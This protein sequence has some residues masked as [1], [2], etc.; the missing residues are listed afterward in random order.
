[1]KKKNI[2]I[3]KSEI[4]QELYN[5]VNSEIIPDLDV[6]I[7]EFWSG[8][9]KNAN[10][11]A[12]INKSL[13]K[14]REDIQKKI[15]NWH[16][17]NKNNF[18]INIYKNFLTEIGY[19]V[20]QEGEFKIETTNVDDEIS[21][22][23]GP[24]LVVPVDNARY[25]LNAANARWGS[26]YDALYG[27]DII[28]E[29]GGCQK[30]Q[31]YNPKRG[32]KVISDGRKFLDD[33]FKL[34]SGSWTQVVKFE[35]VE[36]NLSFYL[37]NSSVT[38]LEDKAKFIG[39]TGNKKFPDSLFLKNNNLHI[40]IKID[41]NHSIGKSDKAKISDIIFESAISTIM[42]LE[43]SVA[44]IDT[45]DKVKCYRNWLGIMK[46]SLTVKIRKGEKFL[47]RKL[48]SDKEFL[49]KQ[50]NKNY[51]HGRS[52]LLIRNVGH[53]MTSPAI[54]LDDGSEIPEGIMD[55][56]ISVLCA[57]HDFKLKK[58]SRK[59]S[60]YIV[61][62][63]MHGP[64]EVAFADKLF[65]KVEETL[66]LSPNT[67]KMGIMDEERRTTV[68][69]KEAIRNAKKRIVFINTGFLD[70]TGDEMHTSFEAGPMIFKGEMK[71]SSWLNTY[72]DW[73]V[74]IGL[75]CGFSGKAQIGKG[76]WAMPDRMKD[77]VE[78]KIGH[79]KA[80]ANCAWVPS[81]TAATLHSIHYH[82]V[83][84]FQRH[85][86]IAKRK[87]AKLDNILE[88]PIA[89]RPNW[90]AEAIQK[91]IDNNCQGILGYVVRWVDQ[92]IGCSKV[93]D[94]NNI[95]LME[96]RATLRISSQHLANWLRHEVCSEEQVLQ[97]MKKM[98]KVVDE[99]NSND[100]NYEPMDNNF[101]KSIAFK[102]ACELVFEGKNQPSGYTEP[103]L[104][105]KRLEKKIN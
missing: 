44:A 87:K 25:A 47:N 74:D 66:K 88:I 50:D 97:S 75:E 39:Y 72:E 53:L 29:E 14:K 98:A 77:M 103:I 48:N 92:G 37:E 63:K 18:D 76:M 7:S 60:V 57:K 22:I 105:K 30:T 71:K 64:E 59:G 85:K 49:D 68:N 70:R 9:I 69:L 99:Q 43:D 8:F 58:N 94:I 15:N 78:Q 23:A 17:S 52:L 101:E 80:G 82:K 4:K 83:N 61:K 73:N 54:I 79:P 84:V 2:K 86:E 95:G 3:G 35:K 56:Y 26:F 62:P 65:S 104:H 13:L 31:Q 10:E 38:F 93:P 6:T 67:V 24:Q 1:M 46:G 19:L 96:D 33:N 12:S 100:K 90:S 40:E 41:P 27:T 16:K 32:E 55:A 89:D 91:E 51:L 11:L 45:G 5:F 81:P 20:E 36:N 102:A 34:E 21:I 42:D 28:S